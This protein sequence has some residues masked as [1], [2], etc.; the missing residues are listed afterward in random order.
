MSFSARSVP[1]VLFTVLSLAV[2]VC[3][4]STTRQ[5]QTS[6]TPRGSVSGRVTIKDKGAAGVAVGLRKSEVVNQFESY[7]KGTTDHDGYYRIGNLSPGAYEV[8]LSAPAFVPSDNQKSKT[9]IVG[10]DENVDDI[11]FSLVRGGVITGKVT[12][13]DGRALIQQQVYVYRI[14]AFE[15]QGPQ[16]PRFPANNA[17]TD[18]RGIYRIYGLTAGRYKVAA[19]RSD[20]STMA[21]LALA[22]RSTYKQ[23]F[24]PDVTEHTRATIIEVREGSEA[25]NVDITLGRALQTFSASGRVIDGEK[26]VPIPNLRFGL[27]RALG[28]RFEMVPN[29]LTSNAQG[30]FLID[31]LIPGKYGIYLMQGSP[32][33]QHPDLR[34]D[35]LTF[36]I[37]DQ[38]VTGLTL[39]LVKG[40]SLSGVV[41]LES[42]DK[43]ALKKF[44]QLQLRAFVMT[45]QGGSGFGQSSMSPITTD[46]SFHLGGLAGGTA[47]I[48]LSPRLGAGPTDTK[49]FVITRVER[50][51]VVQPSRG[52][53][54]KEGEH[55]GGLR[56]VLSYGTASIRGVVKFENGSL[57]PGGQ[58]FVRLVKLGEPPVNVQPPPRVDARGH[59]LVEGIPA[60]VYEL[61]TIIAPLRRM[62]Q[63]VTV[64]EGVVTDIVVT[65]DL[66]TTPK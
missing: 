7:L 48:F 57:P 13:A 28:T 14:E 35:S 66:S 24:H 22:S 33:N 1:A 16:Q 37:V 10:E 61:H 32:Q 5:T 44:P 9:V 26:G 38:N 50:D 34:A 43:A 12:D 15:Q 30:D 40:A 11:N 62:K 47:N 19:G 23:V 8:T 56:V 51:G 18:D 64:Q 54:I 31:G 41:V 65:I 2:T 20:D 45:A 3:A 29:F 6:K 58:I 49:G 39:R 17:T 46:G 63:E 21:T 36:D 55:I 52:F 27:Q 60:G 53:E 59:F 42:E 4:Q 25:N